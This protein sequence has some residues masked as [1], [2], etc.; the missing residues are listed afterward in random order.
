MVVTKSDIHPNFDRDKMFA[1]AWWLNYC[2]C[3]GRAIGD[4]GNPYAGADVKEICVHTR[5]ELTEVGDPLCE[6][7]AVECCITSQC[8]FPPKSG[9]PTCVC[10][11]KTLAGGGSTSGWK[12]QLFEWTAGF[13]DQWWCYYCFCAGVGL[14]GLMANDRPIYGE[15]VKELCI[16]QSRRLYQPCDQGVWC[17]GMSTFLCCWEHV[18]YPP[19]PGNPGFKCCGFPKDKGMMTNHPSPMKYGK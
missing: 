10:C 7:L 4:C 14:H 6:G 15:M 19:A 12:P 18:Q 9:S 5:C 16:R 13:E 11:N 8:A 1:E 2:F 17:S 3:V